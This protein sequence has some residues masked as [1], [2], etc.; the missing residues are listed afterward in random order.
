MLR[1]VELS[2][3]A[4]LSPMMNFIFGQVVQDP[5]QIEARIGIVAIPLL[6]KFGSF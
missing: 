5:S 2:Q 3:D 4:D 6:S 1:F